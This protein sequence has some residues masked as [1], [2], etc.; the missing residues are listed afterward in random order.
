[1]KEFYLGK[2]VTDTVVT[3]QVDGVP[4]RVLDTELVDELESA[5]GKLLG[6]PARAAQRVARSSKL[7]GI[8]LRGDGARR[9]WRCASRWASPG[10][11]R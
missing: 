6:A 9:A 5:R 4:H 3:T 11:R 2:T 7:T 10:R 1:M 8:S